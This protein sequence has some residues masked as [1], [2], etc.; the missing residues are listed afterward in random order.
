MA[1]KIE[2]YIKLQ[3]PAGKATPAP[4][5]GPCTWDKHGV[6]IIGFTKQLTPRQAIWRYCLSTIYLSLFMQTEV[7][8]SSLRHRQQQL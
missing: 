4:P 7:L 2:G 5:V 6:N 3:I 1:K 8:V